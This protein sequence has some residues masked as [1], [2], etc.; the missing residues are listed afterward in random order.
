MKTVVLSSR[1]WANAVADAFTLHVRQKPSLRVCL[2]SGNTPRP[3][4]HEIARRVQA[5]ALHLEQAELVLLD[6]Y[7]GLDPDDPG[8]CANMLIRDLIEPAGLPETKLERINPDAPD[9]EA[10]IQRFRGQIQPDFDL[11]ILGVGLNGHIGMNEPG[12]GPDDPVRRVELHPASQQSSSG[13]GVRRVPSWGVTVGLRELLA[14]REVWLLAMGANK[15]EIIRRTLEGEVTADN[16]ASFLSN[17]P[18]CTVFLDH[19]A[20]NLLAPS[21]TT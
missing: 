14:A 3:A 11:A 10:E 6:E 2:A 5:G 20:A 19:P 15:S 8:R 21:E 13:Y 1:A 12:S 7:G 9:L 16:P 4:Y 18:N 17:H